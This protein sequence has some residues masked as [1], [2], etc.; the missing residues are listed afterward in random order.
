MTYRILLSED[1]SPITILKYGYQTKY[2]QQAGSAT[3]NSLV[4]SFVVSRVMC[5]QGC[6]SRHL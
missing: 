5:L 3:E 2:F 4:S 6:R 1:R